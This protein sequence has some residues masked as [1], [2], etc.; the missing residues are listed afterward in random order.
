MKGSATT[1]YSH[2]KPD[3]NQLIQSFCSHASPR[4]PTDSYEIFSSGLSL[5]RIQT[6][7][8][9]CGMVTILSVLVCARLL[10]AEGFVSEM[11]LFIKSSIRAKTSVPSHDEKK[12]TAWFCHCHIW[13]FSRVGSSDQKT[14]HLQTW[15][16]AKEK[17]ISV[18]NDWDMF[19]FPAAPS[20]FLGASNSLSS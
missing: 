3:R 4:D 18:W 20:M 12:P 17:N 10:T 16:F 15:R 13:C 19:A 14:F 8:T 11:D 9:I 7:Q 1:L 5:S 6:S 2:S